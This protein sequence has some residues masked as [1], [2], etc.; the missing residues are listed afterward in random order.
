MNTQYIV[1]D[2]PGGYSESLVNKTVSQIEKNES[3]NAV[4]PNIIYL[5]SE[6]YA[7]IS[8]C[9]NVI[10]YDDIFAATEVLKEH[11][12]SGTLL[13]QQFGGGTCNSEFEVL[14]GFSMA[15]LPLDVHLISNISTMKQ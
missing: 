3:E 12:V 15:N 1:P 13:G 7:D 14:T 10:F 2:K 8:L 6:S 4:R 9:K 11:Y 5:M